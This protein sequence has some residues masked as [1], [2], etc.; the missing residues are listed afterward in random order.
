M[1]PYQIPFALNS[2]AFLNLVDS[3]PTP[4]VLVCQFHGFLFLPFVTFLKGEN[5]M[6]C[7]MVNH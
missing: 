2:F 1:L 6:F 5:V 3:F 7:M 4:A